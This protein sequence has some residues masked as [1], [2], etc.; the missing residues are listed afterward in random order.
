MESASH[1]L[2]HEREI[3]RTI[4]E[5]A[6]DP[7]FTISADG[8]VRSVNAAMTRLLG[9]EAKEMVG[10]GISLIMPPPY[11]SKL[12]WNPGRLQ[13]TPAVVTGC[14]VSA[15]TKEGVLFPVQV[16]IS[17][18][19]TSR[20]H[21]FTGIMR[22]ARAMVAAEREK[23]MLEG[24]LLSSID[25]ILVIDTVGIILRVNES[26][27]RMFGYSQVE[28]L[29]A[30]VSLLMPQP[31]KN[32]HDGYLKRYLA[33]GA[34]NIV[35]TGREVLGMRK[36]GS[37]LPL[38]LAVSEVRIEGAHFF[39][40][41]LTDLS[42]LKKQ[43]AAE[44][45]KSMFLANMSHEIRTPMNGIFGMLSLLKDTVLDKSGQIY[46]DICMRSAESLLTVL[47]DVLLYSKADAGAIE[48]E[49]IPFNLIS[50]V[51]DVLH[52]VSCSVVDGQDID[53]T[54]LVRSD[55]PLFLTGDGSRLR[56]VL[57]NLLSNAVKFTKYGEVS[58]EVSVVSL[59]PLVLKFDVNDTGIGISEAVQQRLFTPFAQADY[60]HH[61]AIW[62]D[63]IGFGN[64][65][66]L[67]VVVS[68]KFDCP[69][70]GGTW[71]NI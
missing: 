30:N 63:R 18:G 57:L 71:I 22:D 27:V 33:G 68:R 59:S 7:I 13:D 20:E 40:A 46:V 6:A 42:H 21:F 31:F 12:P 70:H 58:L 16:S 38:L 36:D 35:G 32:Q 39:S 37:T 41:F 28:L 29:G 4:F 2:N 43:E 24:I 67:G 47:N 55:V 26:A 5:C 17:E 10:Q 64:L 50:T 52:I 15:Q 34:K 44:K 62:R 66:A 54:S 45:A 61:A 14:L 69:E 19:R 53:I 56:Q 48:L 1:D 23:R 8:T 11:D 51:E 60:E 49:H 25:P 9:Y 3:L 65:Q